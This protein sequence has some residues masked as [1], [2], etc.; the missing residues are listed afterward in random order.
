MVTP[1]TYEMG[2]YKPCPNCGSE[3]VFKHHK[4]IQPGGGY[5]K[6]LIPDTGWLTPALVH[7]VVCG[8]CGLLRLFATEATVSCV[9]D[10]K[11][12]ERT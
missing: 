9:K 2:N 11:H 6:P 4:T 3:T 12:W 7:P 5:S 10:S 1:R 8:E